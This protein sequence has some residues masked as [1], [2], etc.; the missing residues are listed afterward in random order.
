MERA[1]RRRGEDRE[2]TF[3]FREKADVRNL[4]QRPE[5]FLY[6][7]GAPDVIL[8]RSSY[9]LS[10]GKITP[11]IEEHKKD[12]LSQNN[13]RMAGRA[14]RVL[15]LAYR[16]IS[17]NMDQYDETLENGLIFVGLAAMIDPPR[18]EIKRAIKKCVEASIRVIM[19]TGDHPATA[20]TVARE[21]GLEGL[22]NGVITGSQIDAL[23]E[24]EFSKVVDRVSVYARVSPKHKLRIA[25][26]LKAKGNIVAMTGDGVNDAP[27]VKEA[28]V[29]SAMGIT[30]TDVTKEA[31]AM[32]L[33]DDNF[34]T[35][36]A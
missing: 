29:G 12:I 1:H 21:I 6:V 24:K 4:P 17:K 36:V 19:I 16:N 8:E 34:A 28:D 9:C 10:G 14:I 11:L 25:R 15:A 33:A 7:K 26:C 30:G 5:K 22:E 23:P 27:A 13:K 18:P 3:C 35:I 32:I 20:A 2:D 31:S